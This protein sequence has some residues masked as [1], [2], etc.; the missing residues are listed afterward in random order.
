[1]SSEKIELVDESIMGKTKTELRA[2][3]NVRWMRALGIKH[4]AGGLLDKDNKN[5]SRFSV[6]FSTD[7]NPLDGK[8]RAGL[9]GLL[10]HMAKALDLGGP[11]AALAATNRGLI[12]ALDHLRVGVCLLDRHGRVA[13]TNLEFDRQTEAHR[14]FRMDPSG[15]L[16][17]PEAVDQSRFSALIGDALSHGCH[18]CH[19]ARP[20]KDAISLKSQNG[21][22][23]LCVEV[24]PLD[25]LDE[26]GSAQFGGAIVYSHDTSL[27]ETCDTAAIRAAFGLTAAE[28]ALVEAIGE[29]LTNPEIAE[30]RGRSILTVKSQVKS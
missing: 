3:P 25:H 10:P 26:I 4:R 11:T 19:G 2:Q 14:A 22:D 23:F 5:L 17:M 13:T 20:R 30:R 27:P 16:M 15:R 7:A 21:H 6:Q 9:D 8:M 29:G 28:T 24:V 12:S 1:L 18:G